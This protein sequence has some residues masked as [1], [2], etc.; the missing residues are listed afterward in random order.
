MSTAR[1]YYSTESWTR[2]DVGCLHP[3]HVLDTND[4]DDVPAVLQ[5]QLHMILLWLIETFL[6][7]IR[8]ILYNHLSYQATADLR[9]EDVQIEDGDTAWVAAGVRYGDDRIW[10]AMTS[11]KKI[12]EVDPPRR[13]HV[14]A[15]VTFRRQVTSNSG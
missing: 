13:P 10:V 8:I 6:K 7:V 1:S 9:M 5:V 15:E 14:T 11:Y 12:Q 4:T 3:G 2:A